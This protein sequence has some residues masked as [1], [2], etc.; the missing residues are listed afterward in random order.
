MNC[1]KLHQDIEKLKEQYNSLSSILKSAKESGKGKIAISEQL[2]TA[3]T[4]EDQILEFYLPDFS[5][6]NPELLQ[7]NLGDCIECKNAYG[8]SAD[9]HSI[10]QLS[11]KSIMIGG[12]NGALYHATI[13]E[14]GNV[15]LSDRIECKDADGYPAYIYSIIQLS[16]K[17][18]M[19][20]GD[21]GALYYTAIDQPTLS[22]LK[23]KINM[24]ADKR[25]PK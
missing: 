12:W 2:K 18:I 24:I 9:I 14:N 21:N 6:K 13:D 7:L 10:T 3:T 4:A 5:K 11:D 23:Q 8:D 25:A 19:I 1:A 15:N 16:D 22:T 17:S 20:G